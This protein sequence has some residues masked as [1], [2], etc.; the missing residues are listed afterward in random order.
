MS[1]SWHISLAIN[2]VLPIAYWLLPNA[3]CPLP[4]ASSI[5]P[6]AYCLLPV[7]YCLLPIAYCM[8][9]IH[10]VLMKSLGMK[11]SVAHK[12]LNMIS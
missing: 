8:L 11:H 2:L 4:I 6:M 3:C 5:L 1:L 7:A 9:P 12:A 10:K